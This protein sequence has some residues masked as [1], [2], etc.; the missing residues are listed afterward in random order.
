MTPRERLRRRK[1]SQIAGHWLRSFWPRCWNAADWKIASWRLMSLGPTSLNA[2]SLFLATQ[3]CSEVSGIIC[4]TSRR[5]FS[6]SSDCSW[7]NVAKCSS[8]DDLLVEF[9]KPRT[10]SS[11][12]HFVVSANSLVPA[13]VA[14]LMDDPQLLRVVG[15]S[16]I[17]NHSFGI[18]FTSACFRGEG[19]KGSGH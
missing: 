9:G 11:F 1:E 7:L 19:Q 5:T 12:P 17:P 16:P 18:D 8:S 4:R 2:A 14:L 15:N 13:K 6:S 10:D 3:R